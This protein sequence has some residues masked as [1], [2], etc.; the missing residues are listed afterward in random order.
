MGGRFRGD[1]RLVAAR[2]LLRL[3]LGLRVARRHFELQPDRVASGVKRHLIYFACRHF[4]FSQRAAGRPS[5]A[6]S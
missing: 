1:G 4:S 2:P 5:A 3:E 6:A